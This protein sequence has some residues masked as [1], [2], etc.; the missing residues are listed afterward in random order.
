M[1]PAL[2]IRD[3]LDNRERWVRRGSIAC[4]AGMVA[5]I[6]T[7]TRAPIAALISYAVIGMAITVIVTLLLKSRY[8]CPICK[9]R[10][11]IDGGGSPASCPHCHTDFDQPMLNNS[12]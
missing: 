1:T 5:A 11:K 7:S 9:A 6:A 12:M 2:R 8:R 3:Y 10:L 4:S